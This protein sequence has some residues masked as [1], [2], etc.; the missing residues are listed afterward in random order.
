ML[1][2][3]SEQVFSAIHHKHEFL[4]FYSARFGRWDNGNVWT[5]KRQQIVAQWDV[6]L[7]RD[8]VQWL[9]VFPVFLLNL[10]VGSSKEKSPPS[11]VNVKCEVATRWV[12]IDMV[13]PFI[14]LFSSVRLNLVKCRLL[15][16]TTKEKWWLLVR[17]FQC[18]SIRCP[19]AMRLICTRQQTVLSYSKN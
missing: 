16:F 9:G 19:I 17:S 8:A 13:S 2:L 18:Q 3:L 7:F 15:S 1:Y 10:I 12:R 11:V 6:G 5:W 14:C 4:H